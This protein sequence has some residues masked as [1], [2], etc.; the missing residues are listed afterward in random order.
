[1]KHKSTVTE[2]KDGRLVYE[3]SYSVECNHPSEHTT[4]ARDVEE[5][6]DVIPKPRVGNVYIPVTVSNT[7]S[8]NENT[9]DHLAWALL[10]DVPDGIGGNS[11]PDIKRFHGWRGTTNNIARYAEGVRKC[12]SVKVAGKYSKKLRI[13]FGPDLYP[14]R[15]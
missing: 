3:L 11:N 6:I 7:M 13:V 14:E 12:E 5:M 9:R 2:R 1:M 10:E 15:D 8:R 4:E